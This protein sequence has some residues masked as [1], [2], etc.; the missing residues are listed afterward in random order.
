MTTQNTTPSDANPS[1]V[2][3]ALEEKIR[4]I[5]ESRAD[6]PERLAKARVDADEARGW[7]LIEEPWEGQCEEIASLNTDSWMTLPNIL[8]KELWGARLCFDILDCGDDFDRIDEVQARY[9]STVGGD[10]GQMMLLAMSALST[11]ASLVVPQMV[12]EIEQRA[13][14]YDTRV[15]LAEARAKAWRGR[16][17]EVRG[18]QDDAAD[19]AVKP[20]DGYDIGANALDPEEPGEA[21]Q[22]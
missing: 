18:A 8:A 13:S 14:N 4:R 6:Q 5:Q 7:S 17:S 12:D 19:C 3:A 20:I 10:P 11:I 2:I 21:R 15:M 16:V 9:F 1:E 22:R